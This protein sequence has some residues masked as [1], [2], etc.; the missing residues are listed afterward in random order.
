M[1]KRMN[2]GILFVLLTALFEL[3]VV[4]MS[5]DGTGSE[6][7]SFFSA[8]PQP[9][10]NING[11]LREVLTR[12]G[13]R[14]RASE[15]KTSE[16]S[17]TLALDTSPYSYGYIIPYVTNQNN[18]R[19]NLG[20]NNITRASVTKGSNPTA[21]VLI[22][23][24]NQ[25]GAAVGTQTYSLRANQMLQINNI[26][27]A[28]GGG[29][30]TGYLTIYSDVSITAWASVILNSTNDPSIEMAVMPQDNKPKS[31]LEGLGPRML[32]PSSTSSVP[33]QS[34]LIVL[35]YSVNPS[36]VIARLYDNVGVEVGDRLLPMESG[37]L[38]VDED[39]RRNLPGTYGQIIVELDHQPHYDETPFAKLI[40]LS[41]VATA[42]GTGAF[43][44][45]FALPRLASTAIAG[46]WEGT[47][48]GGL[49]NAQV[50]ATIWQEE[51]TLYGTIEF[52]SGTYPYTF[53]KQPPMLTLT[54]DVIDGQYG[55]DV[56]NE[57]QDNGTFFV[58]RF[59]GTISGA[60]FNGRM[61]FLYEHEQKDVGTFTLQRTGNAY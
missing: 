43:F 9:A 36:N 30:M 39:I 29:Q 26:I 38:F 45:G 33:F 14:P 25:H 4:A 37:G 16:Y 46:L 59:F 55:L 40:A 48:N 34:S 13:Q 17:N 2:M 57:T 41:V 8:G 19:T 52:L 61:L 47:L 27:G 10:P 22:G 49:F 56:H 28:L 31:R 60:T 23:L 32:I 12:L 7:N 18:K 51:D 3:N 5:P 50:S 42:D 58:H 53:N 35:N 54:G 15:S 20:L 44:P 21:Q 1:H 24:I 11:F 6:Q